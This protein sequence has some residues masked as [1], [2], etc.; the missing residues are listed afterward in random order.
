MWRPTRPPDCI[1]PSA[2]RVSV[3]RAKTASTVASQAGATRPGRGPRRPRPTPGRPGRKLAGV[4][5]QRV[6]RV[7]RAA[8]QL[9]RAVAQADQP[10]GGVA[11]VVVGFLLRLG[12]DRR[13]AGV[14]RTARRPPERHD[15]R[16]DQQQPG[17]GECEIA[18][19]QLHD[20]RVAPLRGIAE[21]GELVLGRAR[22]ARPPRC[23]ARA[24][25]RSGRARC[26]RAPVPLPAAAH[27]RS[28]RTADGQGSARRR[29]A[30]QASAIPP[31]TQWEGSGR[32]QRDP[33]TTLT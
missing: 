19:R 5:P 16:R 1:Q 33:G 12:G 7:L 14:R 25:G 6:H 13:D 4:G 9:R 28:T 11:L 22:S 30:E 18:V 15:E 20:Q 26:W 3:A 10:L 32:V 24:P 29:R 8:V 31:P 21:I 27:G 23:R 2:G 17:D